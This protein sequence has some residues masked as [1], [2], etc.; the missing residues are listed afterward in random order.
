MYGLNIDPRNQKGD[1]TPAALRALGVEWVRFTFKD[2]TGGDQPDPGAVQFY[3]QKIEAWARAEI[4]S[5]VILTNETCPGKPWHAA[6][7]QEWHTYI[8]RYVERARRLAAILAPWRPTFQIW[9]EPDFDPQPGYEPTLRPNLF[10]RMLGRA[11]DAIKGVDPGLRVITGGLSSGHPSWLARVIQA[12]DRPLPAD[13]VAIHPYTKRPNPNWPSPDWG[14]GYVGDLIRGY[15]QVINRPLWIS[16]IGEHRL[17][18]DGQA[19]YLRRFYRAMTT[20]FSNAVEQVFWFCYSDGMVPPFGLLDAADQR[21]PAYFAYRETA[22][23]RPP[24]EEEPPAYAVEYLDHNT[25]AT[26]VAGQTNAVRVTI[27]NSSNRTW[28]AGGPHPFRLGYRWYTRAGQEAPA[29]LWD[30]NRTGLPADLRPKQSVSLNCNLNAPRTPGDYEVRWDMVEELRTWFAWQGVPTLDVAVA[31]N[32]PDIGEP[33]LGTGVRL[34]AS[35]N[36]RQE[37]FDNLRQAIDNDPFTRWSTMLPQQPG[38][39]FQ[40]DLGEVRTVRQLRLDTER[41]PN[42]YPRGYVVRVSPDGQQ[43]DKVAE[44]PANDRPLQVAFEPRP[45]RYL[46]VEQT[47][48]SDRWWWS[49]HEVEIAAG[50][51]LSARASHNNVLA[52]D[53]NL[54]QA[55]DGRPETRWS[56]RQPQQPGMWFEIDLNETGTVSGLFLDTAGSPND[57]PRGYVVSLSVDGQQW[58]EVAR[59]DQ[60]DRALDVSFDPRPARFLR[61]EQTGRSNFWWWSIHGVTVRR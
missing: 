29:S 61:V 42:D 1:P 55:L 4:G 53:D 58:Q 21:K 52:G 10:A 22:P 48:S 13:A 60:N 43:W 11:Y 56:S 57:F 18:A 44:N 40:I 30:D 27:R 33:P 20:Q 23:P 9:N 39:W 49:V 7:D 31:V 28:P 5:L 38:M 26:M 8:D 37:G 19:E 12:L 25:P 24:L 32:A 34:S 50:V 47:G 46:R 3:T 15:R 17:D 59:R 16:E 6:P 14:T 51:Q 45:A 41:S 2:A 54:R 36:N 35:H